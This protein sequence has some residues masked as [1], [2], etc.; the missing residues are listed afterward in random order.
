VALPCKILDLVPRNVACSFVNLCG[1]CFKHSAFMA[2]LHGVW[3][4]LPVSHFYGFDPGMGL[5]DFTASSHW[6]GYLNLGCT[7]LEGSS[8]PAFLNNSAANV[9]KSLNSCLKVSTLLGGWGSYYADN[10][11]MGARSEGDCPSC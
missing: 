7:S 2:A 6:M 1:P 4:A 9:P 8:V 10:G 5:L 3:R 11:R